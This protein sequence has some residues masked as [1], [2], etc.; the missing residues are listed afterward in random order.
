MLGGNAF[1]NRGRPLCVQLTHHIH[2]PPCVSPATMSANDNIALNEN[3]WAQ[4][5]RNLPRATLFPRDGRSNGHPDC[6]SIFDPKL[7]GGYFHFFLWAAGATTV[8]KE[9]V[10]R[11]IDEDQLARPQPFL[12]KPA[13]R[14]KCKDVACLGA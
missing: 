5:L 4:N 3:Y 12:G 1:R 8:E 6:Y 9:R 13:S 14:K 7:R 2:P 10:Q 11:D